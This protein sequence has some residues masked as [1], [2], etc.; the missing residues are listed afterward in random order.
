MVRVI[1]TGTAEM[2]RAQSR[3]RADAKGPLYGDPMWREQDELMGAKQL[4]QKEERDFK[5]VLLS[6]VK[7]EEFS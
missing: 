4:S 3:G 2:I 7:S 5:R 1:G 6:T